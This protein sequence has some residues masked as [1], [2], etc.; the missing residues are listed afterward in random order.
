MMR[1]NARKKSKREQQDISG[2]RIRV[3]F[4]LADKAA[5]KGDMELASNYVDQARKI[6][7]KFNVRMPRELK[8]K[9]CRY[10]YHHLMPGKTSRSR[11]NS[12]EKRVEVECLHCKRKMFYPYVREVK[13][14]RKSR[15]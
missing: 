5:L 10:C 1:R 11:L 4:S 15:D 12:A 14:R 2:E 6:G 9:F 13:E 8:R 7:M 3:L